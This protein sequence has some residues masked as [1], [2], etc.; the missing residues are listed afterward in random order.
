MKK[1]MLIGAL[2]LGLFSTPA[3][4]QTAPAPTTPPNF[5]EITPERAHSAFC[6]L[7]QLTGKFSS[8]RS[9]L[10]QDHRVTLVSNEGAEQARRN[11][12]GLCMSMTQDYQGFPG[13]DPSEK[14][15][16]IE[17]LKEIVFLFPEGNIRC[18]PTQDPPIQIE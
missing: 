14:K 3:L 15:V 18:T 4:T 13:P 6:L 1:H 7:M 12:V 11:A 5:P 2:A 16:F 17:N 8:C 9:W 10:P